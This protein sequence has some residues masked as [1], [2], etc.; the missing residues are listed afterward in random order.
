MSA[1]READA[2]AADGAREA[3]G[4]GGP[5]AWLDAPGR[6][7][8]DRVAAV[9]AR[10]AG[11]ARLPEAEF[12]ALALAL[13]AWQ[14]ARCAAVDRVARAFAGEGAIRS[15]D[16][17]PGVPADAFKTAR[18]AC[19]DPRYTVRAFHTSGTTAER[20]GRHEFADLALYDAAAL[21]SA[22]RY[23]FPKGLG[24]YDLVLLA[25][26]ETDAPHSSLTYM[27]ARF[28][29]AAKQPWARGRPWMIARGALDVAH[30]RKT[31]RRLAAQPR[32]VAVLG[33]SFAFV[34][35][36][37]ALKPGERWPLPPGSFVMP[38]GG[39]KGRSRELSRGEL[40]ELLFA[41]FNVPPT[42]VVYEYGMTELSS[43]AYEAHGYGVPPGRYVPPP[44]MRV[45]AVDPETL[46][47]RPRGEPGILR[48][49][50][51][52]NVGSTVALQTA[53]VGVVHPDG[54]FEVHGRAPGATP[55]GCA[56][57][58]DALLSGGA[59]GEA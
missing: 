51:L 22:Q 25:P 4:V 41:R 55:R 3:R 58:L 15:L 20:P 30:L 27:L 13:F 36:D 12:D 46:A 52:A 39:F 56:R 11:A 57:A 5:D 14:R 31:L 16:A 19:F 45:D 2:G 24:A 17:L 40:E 9:I 32:D 42:R 7:L 33:A 35:L 8:R 38:T 44:W 6:A 50:D 10:G 18:I 59:G 49:V 28:H 43:Q 23:L 48:I 53:D 1:R 54:A 47:V 26:D 37:E 29:A 21:A 34:H